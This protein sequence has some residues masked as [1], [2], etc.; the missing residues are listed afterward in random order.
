MTHPKTWSD[1][2][3]E[4]LMAAGEAWADANAA[5]D[6]LEE[7]KNTVL[8]QLAADSNESSVA[9]KE[10]YARAH[11]DFDRHLRAMVNARKAANRAK[12][13]YDSAKVWVECKRTESANERAANRV[14]T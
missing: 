9:A 11:P 10:N 6:I 4:K 5:A 1:S 2:V 12:V 14:A 7:T 3:Y 8:A 13:V